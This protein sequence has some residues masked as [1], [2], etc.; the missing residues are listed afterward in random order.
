MTLQWT[1]VATFLYVEIGLLLLLC[2][3]FI[4]PQRWQKVFRF[5]LWGK[6]ASYWNK[7]FLTIIVV[8]IVLFLDAVREVRKYSAAQVVEKDKS[9]FPN[10]YDHIHMKLFR[11]QRNLYIS[12]F[13]LFLWLSLR[14]VVTLLTH[15]ATTAG[16]SEALKIQAESA[17]EAA[18]KYME[19]NEILKRAMNWEK[20]IKNEDL[21]GD[22]S[23]QLTNE[24]E[25]LKLELKKSSEALSRS[26]NELLAVKKQSES[27]TREYDRLMRE[28]EKL[29]LVDEKHDKKGL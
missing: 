24:I 5:Q 23:E 9:L 28:H 14:R 6:I 7:A 10:V 21:I 11:A 17:N 27:L 1:A 29:Q 26:K 3:P 13:S 20:R 18:K 2:L 4:S 22:D 25:K 15:L 16:A 12:G 19:E 8:L